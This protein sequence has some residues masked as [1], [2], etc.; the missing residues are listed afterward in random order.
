MDKVHASVSAGGTISGSNG[1]F[2]VKVT[3]PGKITVNVVGEF[4]KGHSTS[5]GSTEFR[6]KRVPAP[7]LKFAGKGGGKVSAGAMKVQTRLNAIIE[8]FEFEAPFNIQHF[9]MY[10]TKPRSDPQ[11]YESTSGALSPQM[12]SAM[13]SLIAGSKVYFDDVSGVGVDGMK[14]QLDPIIFSIE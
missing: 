10:V 5:L 7:H 14:R 9:T 1:K 8:D 2:T 3:T 13:Q 11:R 4:E 6:V 12:I